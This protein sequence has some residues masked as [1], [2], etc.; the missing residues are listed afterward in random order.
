MRIE[1]DEVKVALHQMKT[2]N[3]ALKLLHQEKN[4]IVI[5]NIFVTKILIFIKFN[6]S[7]L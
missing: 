7:S 2:E 6:S 5:K 4:S 1:F 3:D